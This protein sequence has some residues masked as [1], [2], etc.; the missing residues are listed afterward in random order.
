VLISGRPLSVEAELAAADAF[1]AAWLPGAE[2]GGV[3][4]VLFRARDGSVAHDFRG[5]LPVTWPRAPAAAA[6]TPPAPL[7]PFGYGLKYAAPR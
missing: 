2:G 5:R 1:V 3:A 4:D 7:F 6:G